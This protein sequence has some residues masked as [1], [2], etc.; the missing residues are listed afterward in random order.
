[1]DDSIIRKIKKLLAL[2]K[3]SNEHEAKRAML[4]AQEFLIKYKIS[5][6][7][8]E[9]Y[10]D[11]KVKVIESRTKITFTKAKWKGE[12]A[13][14]IAE[15]FGCYTYFKCAGTN[16]VMFMGKEED[17]TICE[18]VSIYALDCINSAVRTLR[19]TYS[20]SGYSTKGLEGDYAIGFIEGLKTAFEKQKSSNQEWGLIL[21]KDQAVVDEYS[22]KKF[23]KSLDTGTVFRGFGKAYNKGI[24]DGEEFS[25][26]D[27]IAREGEQI[28]EL[29]HG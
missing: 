16:I 10:Q 19:Y 7:E 28:L 3:S 22:N 18:I 25:I 21:V 9:A 27:K 5:I 14:I 13:H 1:M 23:E 26:S 20:K 15:N 6:K 2:S 29:Q 24:E 17:V 12:L 11:K 8:V 4:K